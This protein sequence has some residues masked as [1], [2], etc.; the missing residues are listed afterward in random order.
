M[1]KSKRTRFSCESVTNR[2]RDVLKLIKPGPGIV[3]RPAL[4]NVPDGGRVKAPVLKY[5]KVV[6]SEADRATGWPVASA[7]SEK[8][9][10]PEALMLWLP[11]SCAVRGVPDWTCPYPEICQ[12]PSNLAS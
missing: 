5:R 6:R 2:S 3:F 4:P 12:F 9:A 1:R 11:R 7:R 8:K 10:A